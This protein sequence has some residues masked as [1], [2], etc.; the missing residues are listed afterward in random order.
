ME[1]DPR[2]RPTAADLRDALAEMRVESL[3]IATTSVFAHHRAD[4]NDPTVSWASETR[5]QDLS[6]EF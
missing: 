5:I 4:P 6:S 2:R 1:N 3:G